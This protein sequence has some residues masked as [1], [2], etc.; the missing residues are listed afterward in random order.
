LRARILL[1]FSFIIIFLKFQGQI[2]FE[3]KK[4]NV[5]SLYQVLPNMEGNEKVDAINKLALASFQSCPDS[6][7]NLAAKA[8]QLSQELNYKKGIADGYFNIGN[9]FFII[10]SLK[11]S[12]SYYLDALS[13]YEDL[14]PSIEM[15]LLLCQ[16]GNLNYM[17]DRLDK[18]IIYD[19]WA[20]MIFNH[21]PE[22]GYESYPLV[23]LG[24]L[25]AL[26]KEFDSAY[27]CYDMALELL[28]KHPDPWKETIVYLNYGWTTSID[29]H[30]ND[31]EGALK[32]LYKGLE[33]AKIYGL[34][35][36][37]VLCNYNIGAVLIATGKEENIEKGLEFFRD[38]I[39]IADTLNEIFFVKMGLYRNIGRNEY[40]LGNYRRAIAYC[41]Q[42]LKEAEEK[43]ACY[44]IEKYK[45]P[46]YLAH[47][48]YY[49]NVELRKAYSFIYNCYI[50]LGDYEKA[51]EYYIL[52]EKFSE[53]IIQEK[54]SKLVAMLEAESENEKTE[55]QI[56][57]LE[58]DNQ[59]KELQV[60][61]S[62]YFNIG[63]GGLFILLILVGFLF[64]RQNE[65]KNNHK[66][67][68][69]E[70][71]LL[72]LQMNPHFI[73]NAFSNILK[74]VDNQENKK[75][76]EYL[77]KFSKL[78]RTTLES[79]RE[80][81][82]P[83]EKEVGTLRNYLELQ[84]LRYPDQFEYSVEVDKNIEEEEIAIP[85]M[86]V[87]P[88][89]E[90]ALEHGIRHKK[91]K[92]RIDIRFFLQ[93]KKIQCEV[94]DNGV[95]REKAWEAEYTERPDH[96]SLA[97]DIIKDRIKVLNRKFRQKI[98][99]EIIDIKSID[100]KAMGT[101]VLIDLPYGNIY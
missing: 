74:F 36:E 49:Y 72:R 29:P 79:T 19:K 20:A 75:A 83:F 2:H 98:K 41:E 15:G 54:N 28:K 57:M 81:L 89:I 17:T 10:D 71:K 88:F 12:V 96:K 65:L 13:I 90:N 14:P 6:T 21:Y 37:I 95:G 67:I 47:D 22:Y 50:K 51:I 64:L 85:P 101:K 25:Y 30:K 66:N 93:G 18:A 55:K 4:I 84:K 91:E 94:E 33:S 27:H 8:I 42:G 60:I 38:A 31:T 46:F 7:L 35:E 77:T 11:Q 99:L 34:A 40:R 23:H 82:V 78:L 48:K 1:S 53:L 70:Q 44:V 62:M 68:L 24:L 32:W 52:K 56:A 92:G 5:D 80:D 9:A 76:S 97:T 45:D 86:L 58:R 43:K 3:I 59:I 61:K 39:G 63:L 69:L 87:Q 26:K 100:H 73:F 16:Q